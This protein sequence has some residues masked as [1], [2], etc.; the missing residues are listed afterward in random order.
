M[1]AFIV[2]NTILLT[3][4]FVFS[5]TY[6]K[7]E[8]SSVR[9]LAFFVL[10]EGVIG[11]L[12]MI[13]INRKVSLDPFTVCSALA[14][15]LLVTCNNLLNLKAYSI[16]NMAQF[17]TSLMLGGMAI[18]T[19]YGYIFLN[20]PIYIAKI[21]GICVMVLSLM[22][23]FLQK[24]APKKYA[25]FCLLAFFTNGCC[26]VVGKVY[27][28]NCGQTND[29]LFWRYFIEIILS[30]ILISVILIK[31]KIKKE[32]REDLI[33]KAINFSFVGAY[34]IVG[35]I[36]CYIQMV[37]LQ[38]MDAALFYPIQTGLV[39]AFSFLTGKFI[40]KE[41]TDKYVVMQIIGVVF[42]LIL[43]LV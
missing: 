10:A 21:I 29:Y 42:A 22:V 5:K 18:P 36:A 8:G 6:T 15:A 39:V 34:A 38:K 20:E 19:L 37:L 40:F 7:R 30:L 27:A 1:V 24:K 26:S 11:T 14:I 3:I 28:I 4:G 33:P 35:L 31:R 9:S 2:V 25:Y 13:C 43:M 12:V 41:K 32:E 23:L 17:S 16:G